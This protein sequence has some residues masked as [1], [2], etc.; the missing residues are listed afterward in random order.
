ME[1]TSYDI[2]HNPVIRTPEPRVAIG[3]ER[4]VLLKRSQSFNGEKFEENV[5]IRCVLRRVGS[6]DSLENYVVE[7]ATGSRRLSSRTV[8]ASKCMDN[9]SIL[10]ASL[11]LGGLSASAYIFRDNAEATNIITGISIGLNSLIALSPLKSKILDRM[12]K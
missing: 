4:V 12:K 8:K 11:A 2:F 6:E 7:P 1:N 3:D 9:L 10:L 5:P